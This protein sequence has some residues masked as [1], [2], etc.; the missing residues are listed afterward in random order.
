[1]AV[2]AA[3]YAPALEP[4]HLPDTDHVH[5]IEIRLAPASPWRGRVVD[6]D[7]DAVEGA[8]VTTTSDGIAGRP[9][10][11]TRTDAEGR[12][13]LP[14]PPPPA[15]GRQVLVTAEASAGHAAYA[16]GRGDV[17]PEALV[18]RLARGVSLTGRVVDAQGEPVTSA[19]VRLDPAWRRIEDRRTPGP[20]TSR[21]LAM[22]EAGRGGLQTATNAQGWFRVDDVPNGFF[23]IRLLHGRR[24]AVPLEPFEIA[25]RDLDL[26]TITLDAGHVLR[27]RVVR[28]DGS[29]VSGAGVAFQ[30]DREQR[31]ALVTRTTTSEDG[32]F[33]L[34]GLD[35]G[36]GM[37]RVT[38][39][40]TLGAR[41]NVEIPSPDVLTLT[42]DQ[43]AV[44]R[45]AVFEGEQPYT[46]TFVLHLESEGRVRRRMRPST[47][48]TKD[49]GFTRGGILP[50]AWHVRV[51]T[52]GGLTARTNIPLEIAGPGAWEVRLDLKRGSRIEGRLLTP[53]GQPVAGGQILVTLDPD[54]LRRVVTSGRSGDF[55]VSNLPE[56]IYELTAEG[57]GGARTTALVHLGA[58]ERQTLDVELAPGASVAVQVVDE[59]GR[60]V[61]GALLLARN[62]E[63][64]YLP[65]PS[66]RRTDRHGRVVMPDL[67]IEALELV[68]KTRTGLV[69]TTEVVLEADKEIE[70]RIV[71]RKAQ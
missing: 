10:P 44:L 38:V 32:A 6:A 18:L 43:G 40:G 23:R 12:F 50:G 5:E 65:G 62:E 41:E 30:A 28:V 42:T 57:R 48:R 21:L 29:P 45:G 13:E 56:G 36:R 49:G 1:M 64:S 60:P 69:G 31:G 71:L 16:V 68:A 33:R 63:G 59:R 27:G 8:L 37:V 26:G 53:Q 35:A 55:R 34:E 14:P 54:G 66:A 3:G 15:P 2:R 22:N 7:G 17:A 20:H 67:P 19:A 25:G 47:H 58:G 9:V 11:S 4:F 51:E 24:Q 39:P 46:G 70:A 52:P 61:E